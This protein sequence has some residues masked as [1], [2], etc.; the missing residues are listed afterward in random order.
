M[1]TFGS[2]NGLAPYR[3]QAIIWTHAGS[4]AT[5]VSVIWIKMQQFL[6]KNISVCLNVLN[7]PCKALKGAGVG[8]SDG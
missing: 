1:T 7:K 6:Y 8:S 3:H 2:G 4:L 5:N